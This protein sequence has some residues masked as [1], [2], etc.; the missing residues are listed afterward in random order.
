ML[1]VPTGS[2]K[3]EAAPTPSSVARKRWLTRLICAY[4]DELWPLAIELLQPHLALFIRRL[5][6]EPLTVDRLL[7]RK[8]AGQ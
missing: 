4:P 2:R 1:Q 5:A 6:D 7:R 8:E 3:P